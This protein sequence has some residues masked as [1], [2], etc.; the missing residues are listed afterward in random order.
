M[1]AASTIVMPI[2]RIDG[3]AVGGGR[4][5]RIAK[6]LRAAFHDVAEKVS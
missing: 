2:V 1:T 3:V 5:G 6:E 4:P